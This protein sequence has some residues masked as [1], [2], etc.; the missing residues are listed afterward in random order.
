MRK[1]RELELLVKDI[2]SLKIPEAII[3]SPEFVLDC[4]TNTSR[5]VDIGVRCKTDNREIFI[6]IECRDRSAKQDITWIEQLIT[7]KNSVNAD[8]LIAVTSS[9]FSENA[10]LKATKNG[11][12]I[13]DVKKFNPKEV[14]A[15]SKETYIGVSSIIKKIKGIAF[16]TEDNSKITNSIEKYKFFSE[17]HN[18]ELS[19]NEIMAYLAID[20]AYLKISEKLKKKGD[21]IEF[22]V[23]LDVSGLYI[24]LSK[25]VRVKINQAK[26]LLVGVK[27]LR[28][29]PLASGFNYIDLDTCELLAEGYDYNSNEVRVSSLVIDSETKDGEW[30]LDFVSIAKEGEVIDSVTIMCK[31]P[32]IMKKLS[33]KAGGGI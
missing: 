9:S 19:F 29:L 8:V 31:D 13:R 27:N 21:E 32:V 12:V 17:E 25:N 5:E 3:K 4:D 2:K 33:L 6:A 24:I 16:I 7:K 22:E 28:R 15:W 26:L 20:N 30:K 11:V 10:I 14:I 18:S 1:G 23:T